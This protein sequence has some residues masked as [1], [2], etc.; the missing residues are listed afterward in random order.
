MKC[1]QASKQARKVPLQKEQP[2]KN[3][4]ALKTR[5]TKAEA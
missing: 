2:V 4:T 3:K 1:N 5:K